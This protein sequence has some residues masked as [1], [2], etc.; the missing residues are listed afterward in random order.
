MDPPPLTETLTF[1]FIDLAGFTALTDA[2]GDQTAA[3][4]VTRLTHLTRTCLVGGTVLVSV[5]GDAVLLAAES[6]DDALISTTDL[7]LACIE[8]PEFP[9][10]RAGIHTGS[11]VR[12][13]ENFVG[14]GV[15]VA[16]RV[17]ARATGGELLLTELPAAAARRHGLAVHALGMS[18]LRNVT[19]PVELFST[20]FDDGGQVVDPVCRMTLDQA[21]AAGRLTHQDREYWFCSLT[22]AGSFAIAPEQHLATELGPGK[23]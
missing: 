16:A 23:Y 22:C 13:G 6:V 20:R 7:T 5:I 3:D 2:H 18:V 9:L 11:A 4:L 12:H 17:A 15:N 19:T 14:A 10:A 8:E 1:A 21:R